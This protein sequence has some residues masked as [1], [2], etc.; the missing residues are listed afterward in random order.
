MI[1]WFLKNTTAGKLRDKNKDTEI[2]LPSEEEI[3]QCDIQQWKDT[4][5]VFKVLGIGIGL[6][7]L[8]IWIWMIIAIDLLFLRIFLIGSL[9]LAAKSFSDRYLRKK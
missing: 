4:S 2:K 5:M 9:I 7:F 8:C 1:L 6:F 3:R